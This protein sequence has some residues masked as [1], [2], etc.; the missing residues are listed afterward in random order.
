MFRR[1]GQPVVQ[2]PSLPGSNSL[3]RFIISH[4]TSR[5]KDLVNPFRIY[6]PLP[7]AVAH[8]INESLGTSD[9]LLSGRRGSS[10]AVLIFP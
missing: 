10:S 4:S 5:S 6:L 2:A 7:F 3:D 1:S 8:L 9:Q